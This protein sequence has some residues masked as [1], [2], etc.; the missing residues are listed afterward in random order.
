MKPISLLK[1]YF[2]GYNVKKHSQGKI[3]QKEKILTLKCA[4]MYM[5][6]TRNTKKT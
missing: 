4:E 3:M 2:I 5:N 1:L 6:N